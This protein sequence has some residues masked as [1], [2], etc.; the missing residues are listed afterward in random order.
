MNQP[1]ASAAGGTIQEVSTASAVTRRQTVLRT[2]STASGQ[3]SAKASAALAAPSARLVAMALS[4]SGERLMRNRP[5]PD[6]CGQRRQQQ[7]QGEQDDARHPPGVRQ[8]PPVMARGAEPQH[9]PA[10]R[11]PAPALC[12]ERQRGAKGKLHERQH[13]GPLRIEIGAQRLVD[14]DLERGGARAAAQRQHD[15]EA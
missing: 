3:T 13:G 1:V 8:R 5:A 2:A 11:K 15:G 4:R 7:Q 12:E 9:G 10:L 6:E 14:R